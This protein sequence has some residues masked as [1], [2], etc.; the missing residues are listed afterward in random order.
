MKQLLTR[1][2]LDAQAISD[3]KA[4]TK[5]EIKI[6]KSTNEF[7]VTL[8]NDKNSIKLCDENDNVYHFR[9]LSLLKKVL[10]KHNSKIVITMAPRI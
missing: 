8:S 4:A 2:R 10:L 9:N 6:K 1:V 3:I 5:A 7:I